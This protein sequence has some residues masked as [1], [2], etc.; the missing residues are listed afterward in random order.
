MVHNYRHSHILQDVRDTLI[1]EHEEERHQVLDPEVKVEGVAM[2]R[3]R[4]RSGRLESCQLRGREG[5]QRSM[6]Q[7]ERA[8]K[9]PCLRISRAPTEHLDSSQPSNGP[10]SVLFLDHEC[11]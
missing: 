4:R 10:E 6:R 7:Y 2:R 11:S 8:L 3:H 1:L 9:S 5:V